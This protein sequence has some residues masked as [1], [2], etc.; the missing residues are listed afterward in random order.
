MFLRFVCLSSFAG[1]AVQAAAPSSVLST[2]FSVV[3]TSTDI[4]ASSFTPSASVPTTTV[5]SIHTTSVTL[6]TGPEFN[7]LPTS[8]SFP[9]IG[10]IPRNYTPEVLEQLWDLVRSPTSKVV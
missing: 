4:S 8:I 6:V 3:P 2:S 10:S 9:A 1:L 7:P 5:D